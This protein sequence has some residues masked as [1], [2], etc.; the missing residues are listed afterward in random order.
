VTDEPEMVRCPVCR[1]AW[2]YVATESGQTP[3]NVWCPYCDSTG[4][5]PKDDE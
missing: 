5:V 4:W 2:H 3:R 1:G